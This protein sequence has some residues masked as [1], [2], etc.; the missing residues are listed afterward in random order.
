[1]L[2]LAANLLYSKLVH[3][4]FQTHSILLLQLLRPL[5]RTKLL[6][7]TAI[8]RFLLWWAH[9]SQDVLPSVKTMTL[10]QIM[11]QNK[12]YSSNEIPL[13]G[14]AWCWQKATTSLTFAE[15]HLVLGMNFH[16]ITRHSDSRREAPNSWVSCTWQTQTSDFCHLINTSTKYSVLVC[17]W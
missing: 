3:F 14:T 9:R 8:L 12:R 7:Q 16:D 1:M 4:T 5:P 10:H 6:F 17:G 15:K 13:L 11:V 2:L